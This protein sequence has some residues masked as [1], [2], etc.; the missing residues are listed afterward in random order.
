MRP[1]LLIPWQEDFIRCLRDHLL[2]TMGHGL[3]DAVVVFPHARP[4]RYL[5]LSLAEA[6]AGRA[7]I[8]PRMLTEAQWTHQIHARLYGK[9]AR[10]VG[11][12]DC[13]GL[14]YEVLDGLNISGGGLLSR[15]DMDRKALFPWCLRL[16][17]LLEEFFR[18][19]RRP[20][21][22]PGMEHEVQPWAAA[23]LERMGAIFDAYARILE[24]RGLATPGLEAWR[25]AQRVDEAADLLA[26][27]RQPEH[28]PVFLAGFYALSGAQE[29]L[30]R[31]AWLH[32]QASLV[33]HSDPDLA[34]GRDGHWCVRE[35]AALLKRWN[36]RCELYPHGWDEAV[37]QAADAA[38]RIRFHQGF[39]LHS[40]LA[41]LRQ[42]L[43]AESAQFAESAD[44]GAT[45][46]AVI[47]PDEGM[48]VPVLHHLPDRDV[49]VTM[50]YPLTRTSL[51]D[52]VE[53]VLR[54]Q[55]SSEG[56][57]R[58]YWREVVNLLRHPYLKMLRLEG[59]EPLRLVFHAMEEQARQGEKYLDPLVL[60]VPPEACPE[61]LSPDQVEA[62]RC[63]VLHACLKAF[64]GV[65]TLAGLAAAMRGLFDVL[66]RYG[67]E[68]WRTYLIDAE[69]LDRMLRGVLP[70]L[71]ACSIGSQQLSRDALFSLLR[72][73]AKDKRVPF[74]AD[75]LTG[76]Q[77]MGFLETRLLS[78]RKLYVLDAT[79]EKL[80]GSP[81]GDPL[82]PDP[83]RHRLGLPDSRER[84]YV[85]AYTF[86]RLLRASREALVLYQAGVQP[87][88]ILDGKSL[89]SRFV[90]QLLWEEEK[91]RGELIKPGQP[92]LSVSVPRVQPVR[93]RSRSLVKTDAVRNRLLARLSGTI[94]PTLLDCYLGCPMRFFHQYLTPLRPVQEVGEDGDPL[95]FGVLMH[96]V[97]REFLLPYKGRP[98][99]MGSLDPEVLT[100]LF[101]ERLHAA[102]FFQQLGQDCRLSL[103]RT[104]PHR[105]A[106]FARSMPDTLIRELEMP[107]RAS[108]HVDGRDYLLEGR[109][110]RVDE[111]ARADG[112]DEGDR[113]DVILDYKTGSIPAPRQALF[114]DEELWER[115]ETWQPGSD[116]DL[117]E[118]V[119]AAVG[120]LQ[121][122]LYLHLYGLTSGRTVMDAAWVAL[123]ESGGERSF[124]PAAME[125]QVRREFIAERVPSLMAFCLRHMLSNEAMEARPSRRCAW[126]P[127][128]GA[129]GTP[130]RKASR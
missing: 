128:N 29:K 106:L 90:E 112:S 41:V 28:G 111:R 76:M 67:A 123:R 118:E 51:Y 96:E 16:A 107:V 73:Y 70:E 10:R 13:V 68:L 124:F 46:A 65:N 130:I 108:F 43:A 25:V 5:T 62:L 36:A 89:R 83:L 61:G 38:P 57:G 80:P 97:L 66:R 69:C 18:A 87:G 74:E 50:G 48:L 81:A 14:L 32:G 7:A 121:M 103:E 47:I 104:G 1:V 98:L 126:C 4:A 55:E 125:P 45:D 17:D 11:Q 115:M 75:P 59:Q 23:L 31:A 100:G 58:Y 26:R 109:L 39:D 113:G 84:D 110:D 8:L 85:A 72:R 78:F 93:H 88:G 6:L 33:W 22:L 77:V 9:P 49:N 92:P 119:S 79:E 20:Q 82:L 35:H 116:P 30:F 24:E 52:L 34:Q 42:E 60:T 27:S 19:G 99:P 94:S 117:L 12:L 127:Y 114:L 44:F 120:S 122:P 105:L 71:E 101:L 21:D 129:C 86:Y 53:T 40:Q 15:M 95:E 64:E 54:L 102:P 2:E 91:R 3:K 56:P 37:G 63:E